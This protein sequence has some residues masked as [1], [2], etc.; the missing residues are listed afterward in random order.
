MTAGRS[1]RIRLSGQN[2]GEQQ[3]PE[4]FATTAEGDK[5]HRVRLSAGGLTASILTYGGILQDLRLEGHEA[6]LVLGFPTLEPYLEHPLYMGAIIGRY[7]NR[8]ANGRFTLGGRTYQ[9]ENGGRP[10]HVVHGGVRGFD[11]RN[12]TIADSGADFV[13]LTYRSPDGEM[14]FP[15][16]LEAACT[17]HLTGDARLRVEMAATSDADTLCNFTQHSYFNLDDGGASPVLGHRLQIEAERYL[18]VDEGLLPLGEAAP[19]AATR[20]DF[21]A[22]RPVAENMDEAAYDL[23]FCLSSD[24]QPL[25][26]V[27]RLEG[28]RSSVTMQL[29]TTEP[30]LQFFDSRPIPAGLKGL[31]GITYGPFS[32]LCLEP[33]IWPDA[34]NQP[35]FPSAVLK[36][37]ERY[38]AVIEYGFGLEIS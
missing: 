1:T 3:L 2:A 33:Q 9:I 7:A 26:R 4:L 24:R 14:G 32:G 19:V 11:K 8:I 17:Y 30:G 22:L 25:R 28:A 21:R 23:N 12:W 20:N 16:E 6:P 37:G 36:A 15:G 31:D 38:E 27:A 34:P 29:S 5:V 10:G 13:T 18:P 35:R